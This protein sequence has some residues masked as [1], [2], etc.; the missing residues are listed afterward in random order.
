M[1]AEMIRINTRISKSVN[2]FLDSKSE[3]S[4]V[5]KSTLIYL[6]LEQ[7]MTQ[8]KTLEVLPQMQGWI[9][10]LERLKQDVGAS[11]RVE[12][13]TAALDKPECPKCQGEESPHS[14]EHEHGHKWK[15][16]ECGTVFERQ[17][18]I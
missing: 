2:D 6:A 5:P 3:E 15:C 7:Y 16:H 10:Q 12:I 9:E 1:P 14:V 11:E 4:G 8:Q 17:G 13:A 18:V